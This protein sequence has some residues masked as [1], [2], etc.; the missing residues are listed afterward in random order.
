MEDNKKTEI[1]SEIAKAKIL[2]LIE[3]FYVEI[4][5]DYGFDANS[6]NGIQD[7][8]YSKTKEELLFENF[9]VE[10]DSVVGYEYISDSED[11]KGTKTVEFDGSKEVL[12]YSWDSSSYGGSTDFVDR[13]KIEILKKK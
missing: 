8:K 5:S 10:G 9:I 4:N 1:V 2:N 13:G 11:F 6:D 3:N 12:V 7:M